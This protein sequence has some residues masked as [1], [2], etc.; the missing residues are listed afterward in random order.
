M[1]RNTFFFLLIVSSVACN[2]H[3]YEGKTLDKTQLTV[4][5][6]VDVRNECPICF[7]EFKNDSFVTRTTECTCTTVVYH[8]KCLR[9]WF[10]HKKECPSCCTQSK[11]IL[12]PIQFKATEETQKK[13]STSQ[14]FPLGKIIAVTGI[15]GIIAL[16][17]HK[18]SKAPEHLA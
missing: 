4:Q 14:G 12:N 18:H 2:M 9:E 3:S 6:L 10:L 1:I 5:E 15:I 11:S 17:Y 16:L 13:P 7:D 8:A